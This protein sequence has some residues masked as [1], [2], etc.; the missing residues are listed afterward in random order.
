MVSKFVMISALLILVSCGDKKSFSGSTPSAGVKA[1]PSNITTG[2]TPAADPPVDEDTISA[3]VKQPDVVAKYEEFNL[4]SSVTTSPIDMIWVIDNSGSMEQEAAEVRRNLDNFMTS[5]SARV[6][7]KVTVI[8]NAD[9]KFGVTL[10]P[11]ALASG[12]AQI[13]Q[14]VQSRNLLSLAASALCPDTETAVPGIGPLGLLFKICNASGSAKQLGDFKGVNEIRGLALKRLRPNSAKVFVFVTD[15]DAEGV[16]T[17]GNFLSSIKVDKSAAHVYAFRGDTAGDN[18]D[19]SRKGLAYDAL[20]LA[21]GGE[22]FDIC[23]VDWSPQFA[24]LT[25]N[26]IDIANSKNIFTLSELGSLTIKKV[27]LD[28]KEL[29]AKNYVIAGSSVKI[30]D[31]DALNKGALVR[32]NYEVAI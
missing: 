14:T 27:F 1:T 8:S 23:L 19:I 25:S 4:S 30:I 26:V 22:T 5:I 24:K 12:H 6:D 15:D 9:A 7:L 20:A 3:D 29:P 16:I 2:A 11:E 31:Q 17:P 21:T 32:I 28:G 10:T 18:C 13:V